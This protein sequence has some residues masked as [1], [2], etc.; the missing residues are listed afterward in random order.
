M[1]NVF[2]L[3]IPKPCHENWDNF[4]PTPTGGFCASCQ[5][6]VQ[7]FTQMSD[8]ELV[9]FFRNAT[10][11]KNS[12]LCGRFRENQLQKN[13]DINQWFPEWMIENNQISCEISI[14]ELREK[15]LKIQLPSFYKNRFLRNSL[16]AMMVLSLSVNAQHKTVSGKVTDAEDGSGL[17]G[18]SI[19][20]VGTKKGTTSN[21][22][23][24]YSI[25]VDGNTKLRFSF[26]GYEAQEI[27][28]KNIKDINLKTDATALGGLVVVGYSNRMGKY[29]TGG[30]STMNSFCLSQNI[31]KEEKTPQP[32]KLSLY[33]NIAQENEVFLKPEAL[34]TEKGSE[35]TAFGEIESLQVYDYYSGKNYKISYK[36]EENGELKLNIS[37]VPNGLY[38]VRLLQQNS[39]DTEKP[40]VS[41]AR[42]VV[43]R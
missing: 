37:K 14:E 8:T 7:D 12:S 4:T 5:K 40:I 10:I 1:K 24:E 36:K 30:I 38:V 9:A 39:L 23:G 18:V 31:V 26:V 25:E 33:P 13:F 35:K 2:Q 27:E 15:D 28:A 32:T 20:I 6:N 43:E 17:P 19:Q 42:L 29:V 11:T 3:S 21:E 16:A 41:M 22:K 34:E